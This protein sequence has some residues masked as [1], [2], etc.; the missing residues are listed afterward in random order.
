MRTAV[1]TAILVTTLSQL[2][3]LATAATSGDLPTVAS[4]ARRCERIARRLA[5]GERRALAR[6]G[7][8]VAQGCT[9]APAASL[10]AARLGL[11]GYFVEIPNGAPGR[12]NPV[13]APVGCRSS[14]LERPF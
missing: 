6:P 8:G 10:G 11:T 2:P 13:N 7:C 12:C 1:A 5:A 3:P 14:A 4:R 9:G